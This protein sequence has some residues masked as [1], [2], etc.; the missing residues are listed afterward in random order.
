MENLVEI[1]KEEVM[2]YGQAAFNSR[3]FPIFDDTRQSYTI[4]AVSK[5]H[6]K[7]LP[8]GVIVMAR[9]EGEYIIIEADNTDRPL[10][11][12]LMARGIPRERIILAYVGEALPKAAP[13]TH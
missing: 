13:A 3:L 2:D 6:G 5:L 9:L 1:V 7:T 11:E 12:A 4:A 8:M 10:Y